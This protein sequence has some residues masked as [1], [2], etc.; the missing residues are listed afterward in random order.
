MSNPF[1]K[2]KGPFKIDKLLKLSGL[3]NFNNFNNI[4]I[5]DIKDLSTSTSKDITFFSFKK[6]FESSIQN[7][8]SFLYY[9]R[10]FK[11]LFTCKL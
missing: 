4:N 10:K 2:N 7:K 8:S 5:H 11:K 6:I 3:E 1:F 9:K